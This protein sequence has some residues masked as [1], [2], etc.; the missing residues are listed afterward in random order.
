[1]DLLDQ[2]FEK[3]FISMLHEF[4]SGYKPLISFQ[5]INDGF[6]RVLK[7]DLATMNNELENYKTSQRPEMRCGVGITGCSIAYD[8]TIYGCQEQ[9][10]KTCGTMFQIGNIFDGVNIDKHLNLLQHYVDNTHVTECIDTEMC[11]KCPL[12]PLCISYVCPSASWSSFGNLYTNGKSYCY[13][14]QIIF[15]Y[16]TLLMHILTEEDNEA[17]HIYLKQDCDFDKYFKEGY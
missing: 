12:R 4:R 14:N 11:D 3:I 8:G 16:C 7:R 5:P 13:W 15:K 1:L 6:T 2:E 17:F 10:S 9:D